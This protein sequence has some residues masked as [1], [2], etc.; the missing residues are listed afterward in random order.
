MEEGVTIAWSDLNVYAHTQ[1]KGTAKF[2]R[3]ING[4]K[5][6]FVIFF[7]FVLNS[8]LFIKMIIKRCVDLI[9]RKKK[10]IY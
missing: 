10:T 3:I 4:G 5:A 1:K 2:K 8:L 9:S 6:N 7:S